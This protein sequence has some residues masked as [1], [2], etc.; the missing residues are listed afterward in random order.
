MKFH[1]FIPGLA[2]AFA[3]TV[4]LGACAVPAVQTSP[5]VAAQPKVLAAETFLADIAQNVAGDR[6]TVEVLIPRGVDPHSFE[7]TPADVRK[8]ADATLLI[9][10]GAGLEAFL[11]PLL[12]NAGGAATVVEAAAGLSP[13]EGHTG[14]HEEGEADHAPDAGGHEEG[15]PHFWL[16]PN[17]VITYVENIRDGLAAA[18]P[19]GKEAYAA[20]AGAYVA[21][22]EELDAWITEQV[23]Q[24]PE[25]RRLLVTN[26]ES[27]GYFADRYG[28][29]VVGAVIP[30]VSTAASPSAQQLAQLADQVKATG[31]P[32][33]F[34]ELGANPQM[35]TQLAAE[36][37]MKVVTGLLTH[38]TT[39]EDGP[40][41]DY[42]SMIRY[43]VTTIVDALK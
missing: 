12:E 37:G 2:L 32:A 10:N 23:E 17:H 4:F 25:A 22:V 38:S 9:V 18:D 20:N 33:V 13:R 41:P 40:A 21:R 39:A 35:A 31:A 43:N 16:A 26:H 14:E 6:L 24:I 28:F 8:V 3:M 36:T 7:P 30:S 5:E 15:D 42:L 34:L 11:Q 1:R 29:R 19:A 27:F